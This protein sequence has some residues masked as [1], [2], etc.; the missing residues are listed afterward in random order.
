[1]CYII[2]S[3]ALSEWNDEVP[4]RAGKHSIQGGATFGKA[5]NLSAVCRVL[6]GIGVGSGVVIC[7][8]T[9]GNIYAFVSL[10]GATGRAAARWT[11]VILSPRE[12][13]MPWVLERIRM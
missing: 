3:D 12:R 10:E 9:C 13:A 11:D 8:M 4:S 1:M 2:H 7:E 5:L 6:C